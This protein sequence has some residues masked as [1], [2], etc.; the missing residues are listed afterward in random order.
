MMNSLFLIF[1]IFYHFDKYQVLLAENHPYRHYSRQQ[2]ND[3]SY[4]NA[5]LNNPDDDSNMCHLSVRCPTLSTISPYD[6][7]NRNRR[8]TVDTFLAMHGPQGPPGLPG[9]PGGLGPRGAVGPQGVVGRSKETVPV[10]AFV[11]FLQKMLSVE[12]NR[13]E[14]IIFENA[15]INEGNNYNPTTGIFTAVHRGIYKF[16]MTIMAQMDSIATVRIVHNQRN[17]L[18]MIRCD[19][20]RRFSHVR[21][22]VYAE[23]DANDQVMVEALGD[24]NDSGQS[25]PRNNIYGYTYTHFSGALLFLTNSRDYI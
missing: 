15:D 14:T 10:V 7:D 8:F 1:I 23:L 17:I 6:R 12:L 11:A 5:T 16:S 22:N 21:G 25:A 18:G 19:C 9:P 2:N 4:A 3:N 13:S 24:S 20:R